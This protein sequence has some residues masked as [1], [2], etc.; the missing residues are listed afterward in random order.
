[1]DHFQEE[2]KALR[3]ETARLE[4]DL[5]QAAGRLSESRRKSARGLEARV[6]RELAA[7]GMKEMGFQTEIRSLLPDD[8]AGR[9]E[10]VLLRDRTVEASG[11][12]Q[13]EFRIRPNPGQDF[14]PLRRIVSGGELSRIMLALR[15]VLRGSDGSRTLVFDEVD[16]GIGG[17]EA[18]AVGSRLE[19]LSRDFQILC[20]THLAPIAVFGNRHLKVDKQIRDDHTRFRIRQLEREERE[21]EIARMLAGAR[22]TDKTL[23]HAREML[24]HGNRKENR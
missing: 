16:A 8:P 6:G 15:H 23:A 12:D 10:S 20:V 2:S 24:Q 13:V 5:A 1:L 22:I 21:T 18:E 14:K 3:A 4:A 17:A 19:A 11:M 9:E 7:L